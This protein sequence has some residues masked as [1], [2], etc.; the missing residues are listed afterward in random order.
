MKFWKRFIDDGFGIWRGSK[1]TFIAFVKKLNSETNKYGINFP[2]NEMQFGKLVNY[3]DSTLYIDTNNKIQ[4]RSYSKPTNAKMYLQPSSYHPRNVFN[5]VP[6]SQ[7]IRT[8]EHNSTE[9]DRKR[10]TEE[11]M[12]NL[13]KSG[14]KK[15]SLEKIEEKVK[16]RQKNEETTRYTHIPHPLFRSAR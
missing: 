2:I 13:E 7:M 16:N 12:N 14:Y 15:E 6:Y 11:L 5:S 3:L 1:R 9:E 8:I 10:E 4:Y